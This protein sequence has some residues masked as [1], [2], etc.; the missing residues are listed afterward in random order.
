V[1]RINYDND[2]GGKFIAGINDP[3]D[4]LH[5]TISFMTGVVDTDDKLITGVNDSGDN[6]DH[7]CQLLN[8]NIS[9]NNLKN[10]KRL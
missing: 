10:A 1:F 7:Q 8:L 9:A 6:F 2:T 4:E 5:K 3:R